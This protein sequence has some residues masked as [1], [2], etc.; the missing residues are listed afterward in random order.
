[1]NKLMKKS[2]VHGCFAWVLHDWCCAWVGAVWVL[3]GC[4]M[5]A[6]S[7]AV[8]TFLQKRIDQN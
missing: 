4:C 8:I 3:H 6:M 1:M 2:A 7:W 5:R